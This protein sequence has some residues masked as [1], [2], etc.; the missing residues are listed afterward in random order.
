MP[1]DR[2]TRTQPMT[3]SKTGSLVETAKTLIIAV[4]IAVGIRTVA[5]EP[6]FIPSGSMIPQPADR[7]LSVRRQIFLWL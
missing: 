6:F 1:E 7:R 2:T 3:Q 4:L 5:F